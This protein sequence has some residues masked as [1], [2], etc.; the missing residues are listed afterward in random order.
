MSF[1]AEQ[2]AS[3]FGGQPVKNPTTEQQKPNT[4]QNT[5]GGK[6]N[7]NSQL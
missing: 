3:G 6:N 4:T 5:N 7:G 1:S 2:N